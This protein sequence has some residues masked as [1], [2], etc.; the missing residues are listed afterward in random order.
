[1]E[2]TYKIMSG[3]SMNDARALKCPVCENRME[4]WVHYTSSLA[5]VPIWCRHCK[6]SYDTDYSEGVQTSKT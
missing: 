1:M 4:T 3:G 5:N 2:K 6:R